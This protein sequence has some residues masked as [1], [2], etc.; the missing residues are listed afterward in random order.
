MFGQDHTLLILA[1]IEIKKLSIGVTYS[2]YHER[3]QSIMEW[4]TRQKTAYNNGMY[5]VYNNQY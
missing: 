3:I 1:E 4:N 2:K 5:S